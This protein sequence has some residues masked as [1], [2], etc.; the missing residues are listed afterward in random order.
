MLHLHQNHM[1]TGFASGGGGGSSSVMS[2]GARMQFG[3][4]QMSPTS[5]VDEAM[6]STN[7]TDPIGLPYGG[8]DMTNVD[9]MTVPFGMDGLIH[10]N[11][12]GFVGGGTDS[13]AGVGVASV[14]GGCMDNLVRTSPPLSG[15]TSGLQNLHS[16][17]E[18]AA[19]S[20]GDPSSSASTQDVQQRLLLRPNIS[21]PNPVINVTDAHGR[22][23][24]V[25]VITGGD[26]TMMSPDD[27]S[28][29]AVG[30]PMAPSTSS[31]AAAAAAFGAGYFGTYGSTTGCN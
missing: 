17:S 2:P 6:Q 31:S 30:V 29:N 23:M 10:R 26:G 27:I 21:P 4:G 15:A 20:I 18:D 25:L 8:A 11:S 3:Y 24:P 22:V 7:C 16:I 19:M 9:P 13:L 28:A 5:Y 12:A 1:V 14:V